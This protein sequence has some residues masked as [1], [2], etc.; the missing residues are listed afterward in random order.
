MICEKLY[1]CSFVECCSAFDKSMAAKDLIDIYCKGKKMEECVRK[2]LN[3]RF[4]IGI[5][6]KNMMP[7]G[8]PLPETSKNN[9]D[10]RA[11]NYKKYI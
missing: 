1:F 10:E 5:V 9:W 7:N 4:G 3:K 11:L 6:P 2:R 8:T